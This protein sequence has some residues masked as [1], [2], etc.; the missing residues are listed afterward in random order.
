MKRKRANNRILTAVVVVAFALAGMWILS[1]HSR[2]TDGLSKGG[3]DLARE[4]TWCGYELSFNTADVCIS[5]PLDDGASPTRD[6][7]T[8]KKDRVVLKWIPAKN[9]ANLD[10]Y[11]IL[12]K[13]GNEAA[14][15]EI[16]KVGSRK[17]TFTD[18]TAKKG[19]EA[20]Y[21]IV[22]YSMKGN[23]MRISACCGSELFP[24]NRVYQNPEGYVQISDR[25][26][27]HGY[28]Y[29]T[30]PVMVN[31]RS[32][33]EDHIE[34][35]IMTACRYLGDPYEN[36]CSTKPGCGLD[37]S[38]LIMQAAYGAGVD[39]WP[40]N[41]YRHRYGAPQYEWESR[42]IAK[43]TNL[44]TVPLDKRKRGDLIFYTHGDDVVTHVALYLGNDMVIH[45]YKK[46]VGI[47][48]IDYNE[49]TDPYMV[50]RI[51]N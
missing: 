32:T 46:G 6:V 4:F 13:K 36:R 17:A 3:E 21:T 1:D 9:D 42:E 28:N 8:H 37:C 33:K 23:D 24:G 22:G 15:G 7:A 18:R 27:T 44:K 40:S 34:A 49:K 31:C 51:F 50:K 45:S 38:G 14:F 48:E 26:S 47:T 29:Y 16:G 41:P 30:A 12:R 10:G 5:S 19:E 25:I 20:C 11:V 39:L 35:M 2:A 43:M